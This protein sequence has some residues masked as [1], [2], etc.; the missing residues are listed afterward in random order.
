MI[1]FFLKSFS[2]YFIGSVVFTSTDHAFDQWVHTE[3][4]ITI[5]HCAPDSLMA[6]QMKAKDTVT[7]TSV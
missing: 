3:R 5:T 7:I 2:K 6:E 1:K 4:R